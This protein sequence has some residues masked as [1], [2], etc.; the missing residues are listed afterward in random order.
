MFG[1]KRKPR[2][3]T[4][5]LEGKQPNPIISGMNDILKELREDAIE[6]LDANLLASLP[7]AV[8]APTEDDVVG[9][10]EVVTGAFEDSIANI[11]KEKELEKQQAAEKRSEKYINAFE[12]GLETHKNTAEMLEREILAKV[13]ELIDTR[14]VI[15]A[16]EAAMQVLHTPT[17]HG[18]ASGDVADD[19]VKVVETKGVPVK[20][21]R[22][23][24]EM[25]A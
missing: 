22:A 1:R 6:A 5:M 4:E 11:F 25:A 9:N 2:T 18:E 10:V 12:N 7:D 17:D 21:A 16:H 13:G 20:K 14:K 3:L 19:A 24:V 8:P 15:A 23:A